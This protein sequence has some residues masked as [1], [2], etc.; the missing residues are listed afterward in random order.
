MSDTTVLHEDIEDYVAAV[1]R[2][3]ADLPDDDRAELLDELRGHATSLRREEPDVDLEARL[4]PASAY[5]RELRDA[6][7][8]PER[9]P[10]P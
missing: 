7:G 1:G 8:L 2:H 10:R 4:G 3:L 6:A 5:A 9:G